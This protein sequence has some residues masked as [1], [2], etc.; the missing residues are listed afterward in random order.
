VTGLEF[1]NLGGIY[2]Y[3]GFTFQP[4]FVTIEFSKIGFRK[5]KRQAQMS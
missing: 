4:F 3:F 2:L 1:W 5:I